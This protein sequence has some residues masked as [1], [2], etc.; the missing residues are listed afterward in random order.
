[1]SLRCNFKMENFINK[2]L[3]TSHRVIHYALCKFPQNFPLS[4]HAVYKWPQTLCD[5]Q[6]II[7]GDKN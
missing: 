7:R 5:L 2:H 3:L 4:V 1:M 6:Y